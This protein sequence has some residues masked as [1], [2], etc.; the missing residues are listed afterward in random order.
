MLHQLPFVEDEHA[1]H[2]PDAGE[3]MC[4]DGH[5]QLPPQAVDALPN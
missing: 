2:V 1:I 4:D 3:A 5:R